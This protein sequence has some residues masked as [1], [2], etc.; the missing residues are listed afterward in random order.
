MIVFDYISICIINLFDIS[1]L[2]TFAKPNQSVALPYIYTVK[3]PCGWVSW[4][5]FL[6]KIHQDAQDLIFLILQY[7]PCVY[8]S[9]T[10]SDWVYIQGNQYR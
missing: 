9:Q 3:N 2:C 6:G 1:S 8:I 4:Q 7:F 10:G 5:G